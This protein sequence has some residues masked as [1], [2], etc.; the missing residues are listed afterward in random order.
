M[1]PDKLADRSTENVVGISVSLVRS[2]ELPDRS[3]TASPVLAIAVRSA[4]FV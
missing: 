3:F 2:N 1:N 4:W